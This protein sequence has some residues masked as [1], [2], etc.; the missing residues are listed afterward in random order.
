LVKAAAILLDIGIQG[1]ELKN[2]SS[3][4]KFHEIESSSILGEILKRHN[5]PHETIEHIYKIIE[6][7]QSAKDLDMTEFRILWDASQLVNIPEMKQGADRERKAEI[8]DNTFRTHEGRRIAK[9]LFLR[10]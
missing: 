9:E 1:V 8:I 6:T 3:V 7:L 10:G 5:I 4:E 2:N